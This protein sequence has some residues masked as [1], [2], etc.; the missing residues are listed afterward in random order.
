MTSSFDEK[1]QGVIESA[2]TYAEKATFNQ[3]LNIPTW[4]SFGS[5]GS[6]IARIADN[7]RSFVERCS[8]S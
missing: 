1:G 3:D 2:K 4:A 6:S 8:H 5:M 7:T